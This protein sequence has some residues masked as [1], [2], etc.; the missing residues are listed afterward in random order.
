[1]YFQP[2][3]VIKTIPNSLIECA[4]HKKN[5]SIRCGNF[6]SFPFNKLSCFCK[7]SFFLLGLNLV[8][9]AEHDYGI[10]WKLVAFN[11]SDNQICP[12]KA[13]GNDVM[14]AMA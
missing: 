8:C 5:I 6:Q 9:G 4:R 1:M 13:Q 3:L 7:S 12:R 11:S 14:A 10:S 2:R